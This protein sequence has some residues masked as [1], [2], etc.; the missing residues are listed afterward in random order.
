MQKWFY[1][2]LNSD[3]WIQSPTCYHY[4]IE[5]VITKSKDITLIQ[6]QTKKSNAVFL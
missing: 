2:E 3:L 5:P 1:R 6:A 4:T